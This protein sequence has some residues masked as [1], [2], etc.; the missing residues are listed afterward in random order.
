M[1]K[2]EALKARRNNYV[3]AMGQAQFAWQQSAMGRLRRLLKQQEPADG[4]D[5][6][7]GFEWHYW[8]RMARGAPSSLTAGGSQVQVNNIGYTPDGKRLVA[9]DQSGEVHIWNAETNVREQRLQIADGP[10]LTLAIDPKSRWCAVG[11]ERFATVIDLET[12]KILNKLAIDG[13]VGALAVRTTDS[14]LAIRYAKQPV[15]GRVEFWDLDGNSKFKPV[16]GQS[17]MDGPIAFSPDGRWLAVGGAIVRLWDV[18]RGEFELRARLPAGQVGDF[19]PDSRRLAIVERN[20]TTQAAEIRVVDLGS[21]QVVRCTGHLDT[22]RRAVFSSDGRRL[23]S[24]ADDNTVRLWDTRDGHEINRFRSRTRWNPDVAFRPGSPS[25]AEA[26]S[27]GIVEFWPLEFEPEFTKDKAH[28]TAAMQSLA[29]DADNGRVVG[30]LTVPGVGVVRTAVDDLTTHKTLVQMNIQPGFAIKPV[31]SHDGRYFAAGLLNGH[32]RVWDL[33]AGRQVHDFGPLGSR[34]TSVAMSTDGRYLAAAAHTNRVTGRRG[35]D[36]ADRVIVWDIASGQERLNLT[37]DTIEQV[38]VVSLSHDGQ[39]LLTGTSHLAFRIWNVETKQI[40]TTLAERGGALQS[41]VMAAISPDGRFAAVAR[42]DA[43]S[44]TDPG[45]DLMDVE[46]GKLLHTLAGHGRD[47]TVLVFSADGQR[48]ATAGQDDSV[49]VWDVATGPRSP[50]PDRAA[51]GRR[52][53]VYSRPKEIAGRRRDRRSAHLAR[54]GL[55]HVSNSCGVWRKTLTPIPSPAKPGEG[56]Q[57][58]FPS[59]AK[60][61]RRAGDCFPPPQSARGAGDFLPSPAKR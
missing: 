27:A 32:V 26:S 52:Y 10:L 8:N 41:T 23:A 9:A 2:T 5:D 17:R 18:E 1:A 57:K 11:G 54:R 37:G 7:R 24:A 45:I 43:D 31:L 42:T 12:G 21:G 38:H 60:R 50:E 55:G 59:P 25:L 19:S 39:R 22:I 46:S 13:G 6:L 35:A 49:K 47:L 20:M 14:L 34:I 36:V 3:L 15:L 51:F 53:R 48:L 29:M 58:L 4:E 61:E 44:A 30:A 40:V 16:T 28:S 56:S 33:N